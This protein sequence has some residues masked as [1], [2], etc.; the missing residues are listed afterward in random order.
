M[1]VDIYIYMYIDVGLLVFVVIW[2]YKYR[3]TFNSLYN[4][5]ILVY[6]FYTI[7]SVLFHSILYILHIYIYIGVRVVLGYC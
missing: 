1:Y 4:S 6:L 3:H 2:S 5:S 7:L